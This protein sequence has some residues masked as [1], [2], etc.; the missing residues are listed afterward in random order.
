MNLF[1]TQSTS[2][3]F[4]Y[5][6]S[7]NVRKLYLSKKLD[8]YNIDHDINKH[9][10]VNFILGGVAHKET[11]SSADFDDLRKRIQLQANANEFKLKHV[12]TGDFLTMLTSKKLTAFFEWLLYSDLHIHYFNLNME[13]WKYL[14]IIEDCVGFGL[15]RGFLNLMPGEQQ[16][17]YEMVNKDALYSYV[18]ANK[19]TFIKFLKEFDFPYI[20]G[21]ELAFI[22]SLKGQ[23]SSYCADLFTQDERDSTQ[24]QFANNLFYLLL[25]CEDNQIDDLTLTMEIRTEEPTDEDN[26]ILDGFATFYRHRAQQFSNSTHVFDIEKVVEADLQE[27]AAAVPEVASLNYSFADSKQLPLVQVSDVMAGFLQ[28]YFGYLNNTT[29]NELRTI[30]CG[31]NDKQRLNMEFL[32]LLIL[33]SDKENH[34]LLHYLMSPLEQEKHIAFCFP[35]EP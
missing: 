7:N 12:A 35:D 16:W 5:D 11:S 1:P 30:R 13:Y 33:K 4:Y 31:L 10:G 21:K 26:L 25:A 8:G 29:L 17:A 23:I 14:D 27:I 6:E 18:K 15:E 9:N 19:Q 32:R 2:Y 24:I 3:T 28:R 22:R 20:E 34:V